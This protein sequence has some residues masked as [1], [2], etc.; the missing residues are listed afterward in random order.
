MVLF[1]DQSFVKSLN[2]K[3]DIS[4]SCMVK[5]QLGSSS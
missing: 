2:G 5:S 3:R 4:Y 1:Y